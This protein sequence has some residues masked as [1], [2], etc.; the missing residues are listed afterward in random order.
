MNISQ[1]LR[2]LADRIDGTSLNTIE[3]VNT[4]R[5]LYSEFLIRLKIIEDHIEYK[6]GQSRDLD[7]TFLK[8]F[9]DDYELKIT[10]LL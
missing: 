10:R 4:K 9:I 1:E 3:E 2:N 6:R 8:R 7:K 5:E